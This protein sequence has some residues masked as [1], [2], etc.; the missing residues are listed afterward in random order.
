MPII[1][2]GNQIRQELLLIRN[3]PSFLIC[4]DD[5][6]SEYNKRF[7]YDDYGQQGILEINFIKDLVRRF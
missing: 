4:I 3:L 2:I 7:V 6:K 5:F 1:T